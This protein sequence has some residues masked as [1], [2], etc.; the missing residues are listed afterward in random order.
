MTLHD[1]I[2]IFVDI[3]KLIIPILVGLALL[4]FIW[5]L[6]KFIFRIGG[7]EKAV[8]EGKNFRMGGFIAFF[9]MVSIWGILAMAYRD[10]GFTRPFGLPLLRPYSTGN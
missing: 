9:V 10:V 6:V 8:I 5:G 3:I 2:L 7:D 4:T 1:L